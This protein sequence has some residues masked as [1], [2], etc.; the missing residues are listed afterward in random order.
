[1]APC[2]RSVVEALPLIAGCGEALD[3]WRLPFSFVCAG[4]PYCLDEHLSNRQTA[5][6][7]L[8]GTGAVWINFLL[9][10]LDQFSVDQQDQQKV[11]PNT[12]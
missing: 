9:I 10:L 4:G 12:Y 1:M 6:G 5:W 3:G 7:L 11:D 2:I 8:L